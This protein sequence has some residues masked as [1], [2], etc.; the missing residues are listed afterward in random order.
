MRLHLIGLALLFALAITSNSATPGH[1]TRVG[2]HNCYEEAGSFTDRPTRAFRAGLPI[3]IEQDLV[4]STDQATGNSRS[5][6]AHG[7]GPWLTGSEP[8]LREYFFERVRPIVEKELRDPHPDQ[9][10]LL[11]LFLD[12]K[13]NE[14][15]HLAAI[16]QTVRE[17]QDWLTTSVKGRDDVNIALHMGPI[18]IYALS[19]VLSPV[20]G[21]MS[22]P[23]STRVQYAAQRKV[24][25]DRLKIGERLLIFGAAPSNFD[26]TE[27]GAALS[28]IRPDGLITTRATNYLRFWISSWDVIEES[29]NGVWT[30]AQEARLQAITQRVHQF[31]LQAILYCLNGLPQEEST[32]LGW[33][34]TYNFGSFESVLPRWQA[35]GKAGVD[36]LSTD[37][38]E[39]LAAVLRKTQGTR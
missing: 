21:D 5:L 15:E 35:A 29:R 11:T 17:Y 30:Q 27:G 14:P 38:Y 19:N 9:W 13:T 31:G 20:Y 33:S 39:E 26:A 34:S 36:F 4:W 37:Q 25:F 6:I 7:R 12:I 8:G 3:A 23:D 24:F 16:W 2:A 10:P 32:R 1:T 28:A 18:Q 22:K